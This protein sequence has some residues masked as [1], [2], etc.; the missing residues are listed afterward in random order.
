[1]IETTFE[2]L[3]PGTPGPILIL[4]ISNGAGHMRAAHA[5]AEAIEANGD[6]AVVVDIADYMTR[7]TRFTHVTAYLWLVKNTPRVWD[8][9]D[10][11][12]KRQTRTSPD[13]YYRRGCKGVFQLAKELRPSALVATEVGCCEIAA[14][15]RR[16]LKL[17]VPLVAVNVNYDADRAW[18]R[19]E[20]D[21]YV[22]ASEPVRAELIGF[23]I[24]HDKI[25][26]WGVPMAGEF[27]TLPEPN[28]ARADICRWLELDPDEWIVLVAGG[29]EGIGPIKKVIERLM[30]LES[31]TPQ[32]IVL[33]GKNQRLQRSLDSLSQS[34][35]GRRLRVLSWTNRIAELMRASDLFVS[36]L[37]NSFDEAIAAELPIVALEPPP[38]SER[39]QYKLLDEWGIGCAVHTLDEM[40]DTIVGLLEH[41]PRLEAMRKRARGRRLIDAA[42]RIAQW[43]KMKGDVS[44]GYPATSKLVVNA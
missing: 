26:V 10:R 5:I 44:Q 41:S 3:S 13:W 14:L 18:F 25:V 32:I 16:D 9:I 27:S 4:A 36:K 6:S 34:E 37:G 28:R 43:L 40:A 19:P 33:R 30:S 7:T 17:D 29:G 23:G 22:I 35:A 20:V 39:V 2:N 31:A 42:D 11:Y 38:G 24:S 1:M 12:Q 8:R 21:L 15:I